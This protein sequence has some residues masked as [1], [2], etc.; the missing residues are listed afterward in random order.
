MPAKS[1]FK[2]AA[3]AKD[4]TPIHPLAVMEGERLWGTFVSKRTTERRGGEEVAKPTPFLGA[5]L[6]LTHF[7]DSRNHFACEASTSG[8]AHS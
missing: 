8:P 7:Q 1:K 3:S 2:R 5:N 4:L 6:A